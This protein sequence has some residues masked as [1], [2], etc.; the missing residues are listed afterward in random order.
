VNEPEDESQEDAADQ[1]KVDPPVPASKG[2]IA[3]Q[4]MG[5]EKDCWISDTGKLFRMSV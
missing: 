1:G 4:A 2:D 5:V 3:R